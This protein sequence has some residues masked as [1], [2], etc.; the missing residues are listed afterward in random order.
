[1]KSEE[2]MENL[3]LTPAVEITART[4]R[5][6]ET[7]LKDGVEGILVIQRV[8]LFYFS[9]TAQNA[10]LYIPAEGPPLLMVKKYL[11]RALKESPIE[12]VV[13]IRSVTEIPDRI[14]AHCGRLPQTLGFELDVMPVR[15]FLFYQRLFNGQSVFGRF[16]DDPTGPDDQVGLG[17]RPDGEGR[18]SVR[19]DL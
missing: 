13:E 10:S 9:G 1:M 18:H 3:N 12:S 7:L 14:K 15:E 6:Q 16:P 17:D 8:D 4:Q 5:I 19:K 2:S 11:P